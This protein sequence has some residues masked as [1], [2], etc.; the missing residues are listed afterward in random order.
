M[1]A[2]DIDFRLKSLPTRKVLRLLTMFPEFTPSRSELDLM[3][4]PMRMSNTL[5]LVI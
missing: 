3:L 4:I 5:K 1:V 2:A